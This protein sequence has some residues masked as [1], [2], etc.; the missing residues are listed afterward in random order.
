LIVPGEVDRP[1]NF[2]ETYERM[3]IDEH[4]LEVVER[5]MMEYPHHP[6]FP[7]LAQATVRCWLDVIGLYL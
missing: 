3:I 4:F 5:K 6:C 1:F 7:D 2:H